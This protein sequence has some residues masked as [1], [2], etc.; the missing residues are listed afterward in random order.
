MGDFAPGLIVCL[1]LAA[2]AL[3]IGTA[4]RLGGLRGA[5]PSVAALRRGSLVVWWVLWV[6]LSVAALSGKVGVAV[7][8]WAIGLLALREFHRIFQAAGGPTAQS[9]EKPTEKP[10]GD[11]T[12]KPVRQSLLLPCVV[13]AV[14]S[15]HYALL[16]TT[17]SLWSVSSFPLVLLALLCTAQLLFGDTTRGYLRGVGGYLW[18]GVLLFLG[19]S[20][21]VLLL[22]L[23]APPPAAAMG[24]M[25][26]VLFV[27][28]LT[29]VDDIAQA[30]IGRQV[31]RHKMVRGVS[32]GKTWEGFLGGCVVT[33]AL[34][35]ALG[36]WL[37]SL[38]NS[39]E[40][41]WGIVLSA[42]AGLWLCVAGF[43]GD[44]NIS[45]LKREVGLKDS[46][47]LL[48]GMGG[49]LDRVDSLTFT[50]PAIYYYGWW[51]G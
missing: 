15:G 34:A 7:L 32:P 29:E 17:D 35:M 14:G 26:W 51:L 1:L 19:V 31:G 10:T 4:V 49:V 41:W 5:D 27:V 45:A 46:G 9:T 44:I 38:A 39:G 30:L 18:G 43:L 16:A 28:L 12:A 21:G 50:A 2:G 36:P 23:P 8:C 3:A 24:S 33:V 25:G 37:T 47:S 22:T 48:P 13:A 42:G 40:W 6:L 11:L 20:H